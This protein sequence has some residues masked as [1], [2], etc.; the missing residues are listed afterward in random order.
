MKSLGV[1]L[2]GLALVAS[3]NLATADIISDLA[4]ATIIEDFQFDDAA[5]TQYDS[6]ANSANAGNLLSTD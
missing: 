3:A 4:S 5:G 6:A 2:A 1:F